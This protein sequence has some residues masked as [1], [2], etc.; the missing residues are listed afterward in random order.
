MSVPWPRVGHIRRRDGETR[1]NGKIID[2]SDAKCSTE[3]MH[4][5]F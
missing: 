3:G 1:K 2:E 4:E 5:R